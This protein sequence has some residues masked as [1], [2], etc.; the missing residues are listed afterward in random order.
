M[1]FAAPKETYYMKSFL[2]F[3]LLCLVLQVN[4]FAQQYTPMPTE[5]AKWLYRYHGANTL[6]NVEGF[7][8]EQ[9]ILNGD[10][11][12]IQGK[13]YKKITL[14]AFDTLNVSTYANYEL[15]YYSKTANKPDKLFAAIREEN[16]RVYIRY[17]GQH[18]YSD[19]YLLY[20][21]N[22][23]IGDFTPGGYGQIIAIDS[24]FFF[25]SYRK[26]FT[27]FKASERNTSHY[28]EGIGWQEH[29]LIRRPNC[30]YANCYY[31]FIC[32][33]NDGN[34]LQ[35]PFPP[36]TCYDILPYGSI[37]LAPYINGEDKIYPQ[38][39]SSTLII[40]SANA[41]KA[42]LYNYLGKVIFNERIAD[43]RLVLN[44]S[45]LING[46]YLLQLF[47]KDGWLIQNQKLIRR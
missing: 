28:I 12:T 26:R 14:R 6:A 11:I 2:L 46:I 23:G 34:I 9:L 5:K 30:Q 39:F 31:T 35:P 16:K 25:G 36:S 10:D 24:I 19:E 43:N 32:F 33:N 8:D 37:T 21:F 4:L 29:G 13:V 15:P 40:E 47:D 20:D 27:A 45:N 7:K 22:L 44:T 18:Y 1:S 42:V 17:D 38:P 3:L 41:V